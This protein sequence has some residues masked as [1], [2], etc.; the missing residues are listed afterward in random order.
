[1]RE[2][3]RRSPLALRFVRATGDAGDGRWTALSSGGLYFFGCR[4][5]QGCQQVERF[6]VVDVAQAEDGLVNAY[7]RQSSQVVE[8]DS[9]RRRTITAI[10][11]QMIGRERGFLDLF[12][13]PAEVL[14]M[15]AQHVQL[16]TQVIPG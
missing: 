12:V 14:T 5:N 9:G 13:R 16:M 3:A 8:Q 10:T 6:E 4:D 15:L 1:M 11:G 2:G 7:F